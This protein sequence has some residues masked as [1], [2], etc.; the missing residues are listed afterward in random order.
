MSA[1]HA[2]LGF[3][4]ITIGFKRYNNY[5]RCTCEFAEVNTMNLFWNQVVPT[6][7]FDN[8]ETAFMVLIVPIDDTQKPHYGP[9]R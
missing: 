8:L 3:P 2:V 9:A 6:W 1:N 4:T 7:M 5:S